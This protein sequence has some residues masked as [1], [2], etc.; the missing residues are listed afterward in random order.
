MTR[1]AVIECLSRRKGCC[2]SVVGSQQQLVDHDEDE[3]KDK[4]EG[5]VGVSKDYTVMLKL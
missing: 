5:V 4:A 2:L 3:D 1:I